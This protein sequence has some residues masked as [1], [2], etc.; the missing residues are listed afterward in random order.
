M[1]DSMSELEITKKDAL[2][3][4]EIVRELCEDTGR[5]LPKSAKKFFEEEVEKT[6]KKIV[7]ER[8][9][10][11]TGPEILIILKLYGYSSSEEYFGWLER[12]L[13]NQK[14]YLAVLG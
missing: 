12:T 1:K 14:R 10:D 8:S 2:S 11:P 6:E 7:A 13:S 9:L 5:P 3:H 4:F